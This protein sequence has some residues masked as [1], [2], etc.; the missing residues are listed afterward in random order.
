MG[1]SC[2]PYMVKLSTLVQK[3]CL[4]G[5]TLLP[6]HSLLLAFTSNFQLFLAA[7]KSKL[8]LRVSKLNFEVYKLIIKLFLQ[9][10]ILRYS[11]ILYYI[12]FTASFINTNTFIK[13]TTGSAQLYIAF[14]NHNS[15]SM[16]IMAFTIN[17]TSTR[18]KYD[19]CS[20]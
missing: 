4:L 1:V 11:Y 20:F 12:D 10:C 17:S 15:R 16:I 8:N 5:S 18:T 6:L 2:L 3:V 9:Y 19:A 7:V 14:V 13:N